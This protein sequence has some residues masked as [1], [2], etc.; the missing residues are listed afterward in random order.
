MVPSPPLIEVMTP[1][2]PLPDSPSV[3]GQVWEASS[4]QAPS[5]AFDRYSVKFCVVPESSERW[6]VWMASS[7]SVTPEFC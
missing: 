5:P 4:F 3:D 1:E 2:V 7:G 6:T